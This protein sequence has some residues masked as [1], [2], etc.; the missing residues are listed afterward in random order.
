MKSKENP[1]GSAPYNS[2]SAL[3]AEPLAVGCSS[4]PKPVGQPRQA[5]FALLEIIDRQ[6]D[7][8]RRIVL[9]F[10]VRWMGFGMSPIID[11]RD[12]RKPELG[13]SGWTPVLQF[14]HGNGR[15]EEYSI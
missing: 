6:V 11:K 10:F 12:A 7:A 8:F 9:S 15:T 14:S 13:G 3:F 4:F 5:V 2:K 1:N